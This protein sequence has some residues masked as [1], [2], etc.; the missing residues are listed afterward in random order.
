[1]KLGLAIGAC[2]LLASGVGYW[3]WLDNTNTFSQ[4]GTAG[5]NGAPDASNFNDAALEVVEAVPPAPGSLV[6]ISLSSRPQSFYMG[7]IDGDADDEYYSQRVESLSNSTARYDPWLSRAARELAYQGALASESPSE[8]ILTFILA[9]AGAPENSVA[10]LVVLAR[11]PGGK[12]VEN[13]ILESVKN[14]P[15]GSGQLLLGVGEAATEGGDY[16][17]RVVVIAA[18]R[19]FALEPVKRLLDP[20]EIWEI[21]GHLVGHKP[22]GFSDAH[23]SVLYPG[24]RIEV[25]PV[26]LE[27]RQF[28]VHIPAGDNPGQLYV[29]ID[30]TFDTG[31]GKLLQL[32]AE[33]GDS[34]PSTFSAQLPIVEEFDSN[35]EAEELALLLLQNDRNELGLGDL[36]L[37][38]ELSDIARSHSREMRD[39]DYFGHLSPNT[40]LAGERLS[41]AGY[42]ASAYGE[43]LALNDTVREAQQSLME[44]IGHR[45]NIV[46]E[47]MTHIGIGIAHSE[48]K[49]AYYL[50]QV[51]AQKVMVFDVEETL[52]QVFEQV[53]EAREYAGAAPLE[54]DSELTE[55]AERGCEDAISIELEELPSQ[56]ASIASKAMQSR[57]AVRV[58]VLYDVTS[59]VPDDTSLQEEFTK[60][61]L[62][63]LRDPES[64]SGRV[65]FVVLLAE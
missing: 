31:P 48:S 39:L 43:N 8:S 27:G 55:I 21:S 2:A 1:M 9:S 20:G 37:D 26:S 49:N 13:A 25:F 15:R 5:E 18:R 11:G 19:T 24:N 59:I 16:E 50:T 6:T 4:Q 32:S 28:E 12:V 61:G 34:L 7:E 35:D 63:L 29:S 36:L 65:I 42:L 47:S 38:P 52:S 58:S 45:R 3:R 46:A 53:N 10:Q 33:I 30:G 41:D 22:A 57:V 51:F 14:A 56:L 40:G 23:A 60:I 64:S 44:S 54:L 17:R 62:A